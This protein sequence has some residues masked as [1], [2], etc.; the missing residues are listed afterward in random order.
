MRHAMC[1]V[2]LLPLCLLLRLCR[3]LRPQQ[4]QQARRCMWLLR[5]L[6]LQG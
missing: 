5:C 3:I 2:L 1:W 6:L 4:W